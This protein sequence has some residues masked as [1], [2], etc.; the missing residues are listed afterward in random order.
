MDINNNTKMTGATTTSASGVKKKKKPE[1][2][3]IAEKLKNEKSKKSPT[4]HGS[5]TISPLKLNALV[6]EKDGG[7]GRIGVGTLFKTK[8]DFQVTARAVFRS[9][10]K[11]LTFPT[12]NLL[13]CRGVCTGCKFGC[14]AVHVICPTEVIFFTMNL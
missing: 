7:L 11:S 9:K 1:K 12:S 3:A 4:L 14:V 13:N 10:G 5:L 8:Q 2:Y 6:S